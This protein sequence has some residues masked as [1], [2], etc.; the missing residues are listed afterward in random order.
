MHRSTQ[1]P[2]MR[3]KLFKKLKERKIFSK[4]C[5]AVATAF[6]SPV[7]VTKWGELEPRREADRY[8]LNKANASE[9]RMRKFLDTVEKEWHSYHNVMIQY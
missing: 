3:R 2:E 1:E 7:K 4:F 8:I 9:A 6:T 5:I